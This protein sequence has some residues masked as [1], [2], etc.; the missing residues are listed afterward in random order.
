M[1]PTYYLE[2]MRR[3]LNDISFKAQT[4]VNR[5]QKGISIEFDPPDILSVSGEKFGLGKNLNIR[6]QKGYGIFYSTI[7]EE[8][9]ALTDPSNNLKIIEAN[10]ALQILYLLDPRVFLTKYAITEKRILQE[11]RIMKVDLEYDILKLKKSGLLQI[12]DKFLSWL[13]K[14][15]QHRRI[16]TC[17]FDS[18]KGL[19]KTSQKELPPLKN[20]IITTFHFPKEIPRHLMF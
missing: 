8:T 11:D 13:L 15:G 1:Q 16:V 20:E 17:F 9:L 5:K 14:K 4:T 6:L 10:P 7:N 18:E 3:Y 12:P 2:N 19:V